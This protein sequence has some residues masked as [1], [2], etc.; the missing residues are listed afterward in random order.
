MWEDIVLTLCFSGGES[1]SLTF[2]LYKSMYR[3]G[4][5]G[6]VLWKLDESSS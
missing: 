2:Y 3:F 5:S 6:R 1:G 4:D